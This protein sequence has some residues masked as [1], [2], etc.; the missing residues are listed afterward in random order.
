MIL[1][2]ICNVCIFRKHVRRATEEMFALTK[3]RLKQKN[4][5]VCPFIPILGIG[6]KQVVFSK[7]TEI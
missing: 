5:D 3:K 6:L 2:I 4:F 1:D 7:Q